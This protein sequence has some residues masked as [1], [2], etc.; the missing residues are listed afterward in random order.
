M[1]QCRGIEGGKVEVGR[2]VEEHS[3]RSRGEGGCD[4]VF[5]GGRETEKEDNI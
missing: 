1:P 4:R 5:P 3:Q 2:W